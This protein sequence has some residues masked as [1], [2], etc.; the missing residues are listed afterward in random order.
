MLARKQ[1]EWQDL[2]VEETRTV[3]LPKQVEV[4]IINTVLRQRCFWLA[5]LVFLM[6]VLLLVQR[7]VIVREGYTLVAAKGQITKM[8]KQNEQLRVEIAQLKSPQRIQGIAISQLGMV[9]PQNIL[10]ADA[11]KKTAV[12][13]AAITPEGGITVAKVDNSKAR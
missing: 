8:E 6:V 10:Y 13:Q 9:V 4:P 12:P 2:V 11:S 3:A 5:A 1:Q 7:E